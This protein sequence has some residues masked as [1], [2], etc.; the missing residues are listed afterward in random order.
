M[1][2]PLVY[3]W[4]LGLSVLVAA[5]FAWVLIRGMLTGK[6]SMRGPVPVTRD[7]SPVMFWMVGAIYVIGAVVILAIAFGKFWKPLMG[8]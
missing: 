3:L 2:D 5:V 4:P 6:M 8:G 7:Q 1:A